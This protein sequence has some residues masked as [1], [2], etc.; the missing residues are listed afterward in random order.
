[1]SRFLHHDHAE[2]G[3]SPRRAL[4][5]A[6]RHARAG[7]HP[8]ALALFQ[9]VIQTDDLLAAQ[10]ACVGAGNVCLLCRQ[11][12]RAAELYEQAR[13]FGGDDDTYAEALQ[14]LAIARYLQR[15]HA[16]ACELMQELADLDHPN[17]S[18]LARDNLI[19][20]FGI[21]LV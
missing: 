13:A 17:Y 21:T 11:F 6:R 12:E 9:A 8:A 5:E 18:P 4:D 15:D 1:M 16:L 7:N 14:N 2:G 3:S 20:L 19:V 10:A